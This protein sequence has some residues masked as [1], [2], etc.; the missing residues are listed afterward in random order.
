MDTELLKSM[1]L[2]ARDH[3]ERTVY[4]AFLGIFIC[5][6][7]HALTFSQFV[8]LGKEL[9]GIFN[10]SVNQSNQSNQ[11]SLSFLPLRG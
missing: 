7:L 9:K 2:R 3:Y 11:C 8:R 10:N 6:A 1:F 5:F 4:W